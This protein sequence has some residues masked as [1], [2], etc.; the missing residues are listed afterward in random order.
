MLKKT[1][2]TILILGVSSFT[3][4][5]LANFFKDRFIVWGT[6]YRNP[7]NLDGVITIPLDL[8]RKDLVEKILNRVKPDIIFYCAGTSNLTYAM[9]HVKS[10][11]NL[12]VKVLYYLLLA[13]QK[14]SAQ[15]IYFSSCYVFSG[16]DGNYKEGDPTEATVT[17]GKYQS[18]AEFIIQ[19]TSTH[20]LIL[21]CPPLIGKGWKNVSNVAEFVE[22]NLHQDKSIILDNVVKHGFFDIL[23]LAKILEVCLQNNVTNRLFHLSSKDNMTDYDLGILYAEKYGYKKDLIIGKLVDFPGDD[24]KI[25][26]NSAKDY[27]LD[28]S[29]IEHFLGTE[30]PTV[31]GM[32]D[33]SWNE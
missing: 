3:G 31:Q 25:T 29:N 24:R 13:A 21:R 8:N 33:D 17:L 30:M 19:K 2:K 5:N 10:C 14:V 22:N 26:K 9:N 20:Y 23:L 27:S 1:K 15:F 12:N 4:C 16:F 32:I 11:E 6:Y 28:V 7:L 18:Q